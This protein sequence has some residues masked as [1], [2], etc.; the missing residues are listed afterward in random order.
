MKSWP[1]MRRERSSSQTNN[2]SRDRKNCFAETQL[3]V[4][5]IEKEILSRDH[6]LPGTAAC[7]FPLQQTQSSRAHEQRAN[8]LRISLLARKRKNLAPRRPVSCDSARPR[9]RQRSR[10]SNVRP[11]PTFQPAL[12]V[13]GISTDN[14]PQSKPSNTKS[15]HKEEVDTTFKD[16]PRN[17]NY[18]SSPSS[19]RM[20]SLNPLGNENENAIIGSRGR[21]RKHSLDYPHAFSWRRTNPSTNRKVDMLLLILITV[22]YFSFLLLY[23]L[24][25]IIIPS[26]SS[27]L[28][29]DGSKGALIL[30]VFTFPVIFLSLKKIYFIFFRRP[31]EK[32]S[33]DCLRLT[34]SFHLLNQISQS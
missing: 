12:T 23:H 27:L 7:F 29:L 30:F 20:S 5:E 24:P 3:D 11:Q 26:Q 15:I 31:L 17:A 19:S 10:K 16:V 13:P 34:V 1:G 4:N 25:F 9:K 21:H 28:I 2:T 18:N 32:S 22:V 14:T 33:D 8:K 6:N